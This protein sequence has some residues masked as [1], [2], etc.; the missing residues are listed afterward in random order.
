[1]W[2]KAE[3]FVDRVRWW[4]LSYRFHGSPSFI[5]AQKLKAL[6]ADLKIWNEQ[7]FGNVEIHKKKKKKK[8]KLFWKS[9]VS[10]KVWR[11]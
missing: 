8:K 11:K 1:M 10:L 4:W 7:V 2:L 6:K 5:L 9:C 3:C